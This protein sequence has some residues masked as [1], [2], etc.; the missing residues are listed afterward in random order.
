MCRISRRACLGAGARD[1]G[2]DRIAHGVER[3]RDQRRADDFGGIAGAERNHAPPPALRDRQRNQK[4]H[5]IEDVLGV[6]AEADPVDGVAAHRGAVFERQADRA[7][8]PRVIGKIFRQRRRCH[9]LADIGLD[10]DMRLAIRL[11]GAVDR[12]DIK[13]GMRPGGLREIFDDAGNPVV[14]LDQQDV[15]GLDNAAQMLRV[16]RR[17]RLIARHFLLKV[18]RDQLA[19][20]IE[21]D[22]HGIFPPAAFPAAFSLF[23][24]WSKAVSI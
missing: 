9:A 22:A 7:A 8:Q 11:L 15:A 20:G 24:S 1:L 21:H 13:R 18:A 23:L 2:Q 6:V 19:D 14:A 5:Q 10:Q 16:A 4:A 17:E 3:L 12:A